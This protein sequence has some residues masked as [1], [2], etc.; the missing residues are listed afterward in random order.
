MKVSKKIRKSRML[1]RVEQGSLSASWITSF[2]IKENGEKVTVV[3][4]VTKKGDR[5]VASFI[6]KTIKE[7]WY[8]Y[9]TKI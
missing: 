7:M 4:K 1:K 8:E 2:K 3:V 9:T 6:P 5:G